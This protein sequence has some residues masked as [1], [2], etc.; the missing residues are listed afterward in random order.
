MIEIKEYLQKC[1]DDF[2]IKLTE[3]QILDFER[4][5]NLLIDWNQRI[6]LTT[7]TKMED[8]VIKHFVDS[9]SILKYKSIPIGARLIDIGTGAG[10][11]GIPLKIMRKDL[12]VTLL[13]SLN[14][15]LVFLQDVTDKLSI[16]C[17]LV[18]GRGEEL[19]NNLNFREKY[20]I[21]TV[22]AVGSM[23]VVSE[24]CLPFVKRG[25]F[26]IAMKGPFRKEEIRTGEGAIKLLGGELEKT[27]RFALPDDSRRTLYIVKKVKRTPKQYP[28][29]Q[30]KIKTQPL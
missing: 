12:E 20:D 21:A 18:H 17:A 29:T 26:F 2:E 9:I 19:G 6:N 11:P 16:P 27:E 7:V 25:G 5:Y 15:R 23:S 28:R 4:Y 22:R 1:C 30:S 3:R 24:Y 14:K 10:F 8:V 13:D